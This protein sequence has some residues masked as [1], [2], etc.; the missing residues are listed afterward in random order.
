MLMQILFCESSV[1][2]LST[3]LFAL[4]FSIVYCAF[5]CHFF[6]SKSR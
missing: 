1:L 3:I 2:K 4:F 5:H 6:P